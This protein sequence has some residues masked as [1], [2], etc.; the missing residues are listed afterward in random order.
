[1]RNHEI[2]RANNRDLSGIN[3]EFLCVKGR[4]GFDFTKHP[5]RIKQPMLRKGDKLYPVSWEEAAQEAA[6]RLNEL[7]AA[8]GADAIGFIGS[9]R[10]SNEENYLLQR[11]ARATFGTNNIDHHRTA[12][13]TGLIT[14]LGERARDSLLTMEKLYESKAVL[15]IGN[16]PTNQNPLVGVADSR[17]HPA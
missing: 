10:T 11:L 15:L 17:G 8:Y 13:Y 5:E 9:N 2:L 1:M 3:K 12:D 6:K 7:H 16:D 14:A 4:F